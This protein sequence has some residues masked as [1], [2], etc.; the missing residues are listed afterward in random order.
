MMVPGGVTIVAAATAAAAAALVVIMDASPLLFAYDAILSTDR[1]FDQKWKGKRIWIAGA[2][3]GIGSDL[4][5]HFAHHGA[6]LILSARRVDALEQV[7]TSCRTIQEQKHKSNSNLIRSEDA[8]SVTVLPLDITS[9][10]L[11]ET[12]DRAIEIH[13][14][15]DVLVLNSGVGHLSPAPSTEDST[16]HNMMD[17]NYHGPVRL[18]LG[19]MKQDSWQ[20]QRRGHIV[21]TSSIAGKMAVPLSASYAASKFAVMGFFSSLRSECGDW[22]LRIDLPCPGP[23]DTAFFRKSSHPVS[24]TLSS[25]EEDTSESKMTSSRCA[26]LIAS[27]MT[28]PSSLF[29]ET[30]IAKQPTLGFMFLNQYL[31]TVSTYLMGAI[32]PL[33]LKAWEAGLPLYKVSS[34]IKVVRDRTDK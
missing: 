3:S 15:V 13:G 29:H 11:T 25:P 23:I 33:R 14:G 17:V 12:I 2:S 19:L 30:W 34:W 27:S 21:V 16:M 4:A 10:S 32:G 20:R 5:Q 8:P 9:S 28:G 18:A 26:R 22:G 31:P 24:S 1:S 7:A 6:H